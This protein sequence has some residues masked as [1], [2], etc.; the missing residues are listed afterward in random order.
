MAAAATDSVCAAQCSCVEGCR[1]QHVGTRLHHWQ[2]H[3]L[4]LDARPGCGYQVVIWV[5]PVHPGY[6]V[7]NGRAVSVVTI[8]ESWCSW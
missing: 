6:A 5:L 4:T 3:Q 2:T 8:E 1:H 7:K